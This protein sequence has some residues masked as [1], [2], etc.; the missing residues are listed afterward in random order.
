MKK[1]FKLL[2]LLICLI[3][4]MTACSSDD[5]DNKSE[6]E[7]ITVAELESVPS[8]TYSYESTIDSKYSYTVYIWFRNG[9][10]SYY[11][12]AST[13]SRS[14]YRS[15][16]YSINDKKITLSTNYGDSYTGY[17]VKYTKKDKQQLV[18]ADGL[19]G[20]DL[21]NLPED[22]MNWYDYSNIDLSK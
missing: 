18:L 14:D 13:A 6:L 9:R 19:D 10:M 2:G 20:T 22:L 12:N 17:I 16:S 5:D 15:Y 7:A 21:G 3:L 1:E 4:G 8:F 11:K